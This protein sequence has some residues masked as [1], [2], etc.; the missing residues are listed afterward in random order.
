MRALDEGA[1]EGALNDSTPA[2]DSQLSGCSASSAADSMLSR[3][4]EMKRATEA[5]LTTS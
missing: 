4:R 2:G 1:R 3:S 5:P